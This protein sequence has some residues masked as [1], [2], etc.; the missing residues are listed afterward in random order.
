MKQI[1]LRDIAH[2]RSGDKGSSSNIGVIAYSDA[3]YEYLCQEL[4]TSRLQE[5]FAPLEASSITRYELPNLSA[6]NFVL[7]GA[8]AGGASRSLRCDTQGKTLGQVIL[9]MPLEVDENALAAMLPRGE[10]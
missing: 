6:L 9:Q 2:A 1:T 10:V 8:L 7:R 5:F 3:G 4:T